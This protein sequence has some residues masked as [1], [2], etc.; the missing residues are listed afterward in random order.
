M[1][2]PPAPANGQRGT[3]NA[4]FMSSVTYSCNAGYNLQ[5][6]STLT[7]MAN[8]KWSPSVP[9]CNGESTLQNLI[10]QKLILGY[11]RMLEMCLF[12]TLRYTSILATLFTD[13]K[14]LRLVWRLWCGI[15]LL[16]DD[17]LFMCTV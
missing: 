13:S 11:Q 4:T 1:A 12:Q 2:P 14:S 10:K 7:C 8:L 6:S 17:L 16:T 3:F 9:T 5:G 15:Y